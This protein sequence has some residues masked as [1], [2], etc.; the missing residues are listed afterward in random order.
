MAK[1]NTSIQG[2]KKPPVEKRT[3]WRNVPTVGKDAGEL[4]ESEDE[5]KEFV[6]D[7]LTSMMEFYNLPI[8]KDDEEFIERTEK[9]FFRCAERGIKPTWEEYALAMGT[10][11]QSLW[12]WETGR[13]VRISPNLIV[14]AKEFMA[15]YDARAV[16]SGKLNPVTYIFRSKNYYG[17][18]DQQEHILTPS[19]GD[20]MD[21]KSLIEQAEMLPDIE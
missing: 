13:R 14:Q 19:T 1:T 16:S 6:K 21:E 17:L 12:E 15:A 7:T 5:K 18:K 9:Y 8:V 20:V 10:K 4:F 11:R 2:V 3:T